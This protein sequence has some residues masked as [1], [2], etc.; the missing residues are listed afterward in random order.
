MEG[1]EKGGE[2]SKD[3]RGKME[4]GRENLGGGG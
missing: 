4:K 3:E 2:V 1:T